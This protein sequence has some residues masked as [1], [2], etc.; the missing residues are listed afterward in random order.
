MFFQSKGKQKP[1]IAL[2]HPAVGDSVGRSESLVLKLAERLKDKCDVKILSS[3]T[4]NDLC[5]P[6]SCIPRSQVLQESKYDKLRYFLANFSNRPE[7]FIEHLTSFFPVVWELFKGKYDV[8]LPNNDWGGLLAASVVRTIKRT[9][10]IFTEHSGLIEG[11]KNARRNLFFKPDKYVVYTN[12]L[13]YWLKKYHPDVDTSFIPMGVDFDRFNPEIEPA[14]INLSG[15]IFLAS[16]VHPNEF[17]KKENSSYTVSKSSTSS[18]KNKRFDLL[19]EAVALLEKGSVLLLCPGENSA[20]LVR[21]GEKLLGK[22]RFKTICVPHE[23]IPSYYKACDVFTLPSRSEPFG[24]VYIEAM[25]CNKP[26]VAP[27]DCS[28]MDII[29]DA[30]ILCDVTDVEEYA[31]ALQKASETNWGEIP[32]YQARKFTWESCADKY[33]EQIKSLIF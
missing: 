31:E 9:P 28:R 19:I 29:G 33:Y 1:K 10:I 20:E 6:I 26:V 21:K 5:T 12:E 25:A 2:I 24:L 18:A 3:K 13:K 30:G 15:P 16:S 11:G 4:V 32:Y 14:K 17:F 8:I 27:K 7:V 23:Q 22:K